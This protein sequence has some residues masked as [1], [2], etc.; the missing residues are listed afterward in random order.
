MSIYLSYL[1]VI[2][3][4]GGPIVCTC[5]IHTPYILPSSS[6]GPL[7]WHA[8]AEAPTGVARALLYCG[9]P[10]SLPHWSF[11]TFH[12]T[13]HQV[14]SPGRREYSLKNHFI[15]LYSYDRTPYVPPP[16]LPPAKPRSLAERQNATQQWTIHQPSTKYYQYCSAVDN[17]MISCSQ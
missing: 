6:A 13:F 5:T 9:S 11:K 8:V 10:S 17:M 15:V 16:S 2:T 3:G 1:L 4:L 14:M 7:C 12:H